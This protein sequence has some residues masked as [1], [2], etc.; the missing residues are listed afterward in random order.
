LSIYDSPES[1][2]DQRFRV[3]QSTSV[4]VITLHSE[5]LCADVCVYIDISERRA[6]SPAVGHHYRGAKMALWLDLLPRLH[7]SDDLDARYHQLDNYA[8]RS[9]F[10][11][12]GTRLPEGA[13]LALLRSLAA[14]R[15]ERSNVSASAA[16]AAGTD[17]M[18]PL[19]AAGRRR[20]ATTTTSSTLHTIPASSPRAASRATAATVDAGRDSSGGIGVLSLAVTV[21]V[22]CGLLVV[23]AAVLGSLYCKRGRLSG[24]MREQLALMSPP[25]ESAQLVDT[26]RSVTPA[27]ISR[28]SAD[29]DALTNSSGALDAKPASTASES[30]R[31]T[32]RPSWRSITPSNHPDHIA[33]TSTPTHPDSDSSHVNAAIL[34]SVKSRALSGDVINHVTSSTTDTVV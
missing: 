3:Y 2:T 20:R 25:S 21:G 4:L 19:T 32:V 26:E 11:A 9:S 6:S 34:M 12:E 16:G 13:E 5:Y 22:G 7:R 14:A 23:N 15:T 27:H 1:S 17:A 29:V 31:R 33:L 18:L 30:L 24:K 10:D 28:D 8:D